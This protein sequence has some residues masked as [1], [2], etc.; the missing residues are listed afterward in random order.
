MQAERNLHQQTA[1]EQLRQNTASSA[2]A[3]RQTDTIQREQFKQWC[4]I[5][6]HFENANYCIRHGAAR[7]TSAE[8]AYQVLG[9]D[10][11]ATIETI[12]YD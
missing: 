8:Y 2:Q 7:A 3:R 1:Q 11:D 6:A 5:D 10:Q 12:R 4:K 9:I